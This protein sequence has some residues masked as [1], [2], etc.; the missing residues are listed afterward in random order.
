MKIAILDND[1]PEWLTKAG[2]GLLT[3]VTPKVAKATA[4]PDG[5]EIIGIRIFPPGDPPYYSHGNGSCPLQAEF[6]L[7]ELNTNNRMQVKAALLRLNPDLLLIDCSINEKDDFSEGGI[8]FAIDLVSSKMVTNDQIIIATNKKNTEKIKN[9][10][11]PKFRKRF[12]PAL[13]DD[14]PRLAQLIAHRLASP[15]RP[16][17]EL[18]DVVNIA[19]HKNGELIERFFHGTGRPKREVIA[20]CEQ[21][22]QVANSL[23][24]PGWLKKAI[25]HFTD[26][27]Q[28]EEM[29]ADDLVEYG[30]DPNLRG[31]M[32]SASDKSGLATLFD[33]ASTFPGKP[34]L[35]DLL[36][37]RIDARQ[38][39]PFRLYAD[40]QC[41]KFRF[42]VNWDEPLPSGVLTDSEA[43]TDKIIESGVPLSWFLSFDRNW[44][45]DLAVAMERNKCAKTLYAFCGSTKAPHHRFAVFWN[46]RPGFP[47][48]AKLLES[49]GSVL[50]GASQFSDVFI[51]SACIDGTKVLVE[52]KP[53]GN[54]RDIPSCRM[55]FRQTRFDFSQWPEGSAYLFA[56]KAV[57]YDPV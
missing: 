14:A 25:E 10:D 26:G 40:T 42:S 41:R 20:A 23:H 9:D 49:P 11:I 13:K 37:P 53:D 29:V 4:A 30:R 48:T 55:H 39:A 28:P 8:D 7:L 5:A 45:G 31:K 47:S 2:A 12:L 36:F 19:I 35:K 21:L 50:V 44:L 3:K 33:S 32:I 18:S 15:S 57:Q 54:S 17:I 52:V 6:H 56:V 43:S 34:K 22:V 51:A 1:T 46:R 16:T 24:E 27:K 38:D